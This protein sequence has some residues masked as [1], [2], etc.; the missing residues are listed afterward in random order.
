MR[1]HKVIHEARN[2]GDY[3]TPPADFSH[4]FLISIIS[5]EGW[6]SMVTLWAHDVERHGRPIAIG[7][8]PVPSTLS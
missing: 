3:E 6:G 1:R 8:N 4:S 2:W 5:I 7:S